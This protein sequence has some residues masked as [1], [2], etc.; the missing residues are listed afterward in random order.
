MKANLEAY[1]KLVYDDSVIVS[2]DN[3]LAVMPGDNIIFVA[4][5]NIPVRKKVTAKRK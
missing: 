2:T 4:V 3:S 5:Y 1:A